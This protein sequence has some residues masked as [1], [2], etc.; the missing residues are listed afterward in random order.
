MY[1]RHTRALPRPHLRDGLVPPVLEVAHPRPQREPVVLAQALDVTNLEARA[2]HRRDDAPELVQLAVGEDVAVDEAVRLEARAAAVR[3]P[4]DPVVQEPPAGTEEPSQP[5]EVHPQL[6]QPHVLEH[7]D[8]ADRVERAVEHVA[9]VL[10]PD[11]DAI[12]QAGLGDRLLGPLGLA[13]RERHTH[14]VH[15]VVRG[16]VQDHPAPATP[17]VEQ[18]HPRFQPELAGH[19]LVLRRLRVL[20]R[21]VLAFPH[22]ARVRHRGAEHDP[23]ERVRDV[24]VVGD[25]GRVPF[26]RVPDAA[27]ASLLRRDG[28][29]AEPGP[30]HRR[31]REPEHLRPLPRAE[32]PHV[33][34]PVAER[35]ERREEVALDVELA[36]HVR[37]TQ[38][39]LAGRGDQTPEHHGRA[40]QERGRRVGGPQP[41]PVVRAH[42]DGEIGAE[43][44]LEG[45]SHRHRS[46][47]RRVCASRSRPVSACRGRRPRA[48]S[49]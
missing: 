2:L 5:A 26:P 45:T 20:E 21:D 25:R 30:Q 18:P 27:Q 11:L 40:D 29:R 15:A 24:V 33:G 38:T 10:V 42:R 12:G 34:H 36:R 17:H 4:G 23:V 39:E 37:A 6:R 28:Q 14:G 35:G 16:R 46:R 3:R 44:G 7:P 48:G 8:R 43:D 47:V 49:A 13:P 41:A 9:I 31:A 1:R 22:G 19:E 32:G